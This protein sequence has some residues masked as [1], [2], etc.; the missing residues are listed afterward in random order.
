MCHGNGDGELVSIDEVL[1][2]EDV[3]WVIHLV[4]GDSK[5]RV[6]GSME[7]VLDVSYRL[8]P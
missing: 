8:G 7:S 4:G 2:P 1:D 5:G 6:S 3:R